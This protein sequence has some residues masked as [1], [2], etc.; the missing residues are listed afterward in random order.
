ML[1][2]FNNVDVRDSVMREYFKTRSL[3][4]NDIIESE[5]DSRVFLNEH[6]SPATANLNFMCHK[7]LREK[8]ILKYRIINADKPK[9]KLTFTDEKEAV[10]DIGECAALFNSAG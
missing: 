7:L 2:K 1:V 10:C 3:K 9:A 8:I 6:F 4:L 5:L